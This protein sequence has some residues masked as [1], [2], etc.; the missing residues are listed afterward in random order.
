[1]L[2]HELSYEYN[3]PILW[4]SCITVCLEER[5]GLESEDIQV[6]SSPQKLNIHL[7]REV[8]CGV[9]LSTVSF[10]RVVT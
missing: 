9:L 5:M 4:I 7:F 10:I 3:R 1:M 6:Y 2:G 8:W